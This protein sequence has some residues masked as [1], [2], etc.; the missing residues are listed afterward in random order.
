[1]LH[2]PCL[3]LR[4]ILFHPILRAYFP[5]TGQNRMQ[6]GTLSNLWLLV[7]L[8]LQYQIADSI[9]RRLRVR[10]RKVP[11]AIDEVQH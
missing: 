4:C 7:G 5:D 2:V 8:T 1:M 3:C 11:E 6:I 9:D 10:A